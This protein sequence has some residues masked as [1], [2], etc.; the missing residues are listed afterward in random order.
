M[1]ITPNNNVSPASLPN[2]A[3]K[4]QDPGQKSFDS[5]LQESLDTT[6]KIPQET[7]GPPVLD[8]LAAMQ[9][10]SLNARIDTSAVEQTTKLLD[11]LEVYSQKLGDPNVSLK[12]LYPL[13]KEIEAQNTELMPKLNGLT[14]GD[15][16]KS[17]L[18]QALS[19]ASIESAKFRRGDYNE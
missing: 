1:K 15:G 12:E 5:I 10:T 19:V 9:S 2:Q 16:L 14:D 8:P 6:T 13:L 11:N 7:T 17:I 3:Q 18:N 4:T